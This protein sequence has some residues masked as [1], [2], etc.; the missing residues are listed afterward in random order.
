M[1]TRSI[2]PNKTFHNKPILYLNMIIPTVL[3]PTVLV[4]TVLVP[5]LSAPTLLVQTLLVP[6]LKVPTFVSCHELYKKGMKY[7]YFYSLQ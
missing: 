1:L 2:Y 5:P 7:I 6:T 3:V 4:S